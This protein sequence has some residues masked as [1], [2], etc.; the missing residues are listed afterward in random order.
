MKKLLINVKARIATSPEIGWDVAQD[1]THFLFA[2]RHQFSSFEVLHDDGE[3]QI[4]YY[5]SKPLPFVPYG[6]R[7]ISVRKL[8]HENMSLRL[9]LAG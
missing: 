9:A 8:N 2:H 4:F 3:L 7:F 1:Y 5:V 6:I